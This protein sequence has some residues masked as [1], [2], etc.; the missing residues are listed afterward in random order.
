MDT[1]G[2]ICLKGSKGLTSLKTT[3]TLK[4]ENVYF[5]GLL[6]D[7]LGKLISKDSRSVVAALDLQV[8]AAI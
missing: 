4:V 6:G 2:D 8:C 7:K 5:N 3:K 1:R